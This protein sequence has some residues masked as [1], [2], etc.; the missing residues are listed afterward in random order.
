MSF[1][2]LLASALLTVSVCLAEQPPAT[3]LLPW[4]SDSDQA[5]E[6]ARAQSLPIYMYFTG[7]SWCIWCKRMEKDLHNKDEFR[8]QLV[9][10]VIFLK[11]DLPAGTHP[12]EKTQKLLST[13]NVRGVPTVVILS[14]DLKELARFQY[15]QMPAGDY[16]KLVL[17]AI[18][19]PVQG[20]DKP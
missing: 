2:S 9:G 14:Q 19:S 5:F 7:S 18:E 11:L 6:A 4:S 13:Y 12:D 10:K 16:A 1:S 17:K 15:Q 20:P 3:E 8:Q